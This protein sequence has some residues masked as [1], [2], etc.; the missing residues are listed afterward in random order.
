LNQRTI[1]E[2]QHSFA[3]YMS[4]R[5]V[6]YASHPILTSN[7]T[8]YPLSAAIIPFSEMPNERRPIYFI[9]GG[10]PSNRARGNERAI[11]KRRSHCLGCKRGTLDGVRRQYE[12]L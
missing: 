9:S 10:I 7:I 3:D 11:A 8:P 6:E 5:H 4:L 12:P 1:L 2:P